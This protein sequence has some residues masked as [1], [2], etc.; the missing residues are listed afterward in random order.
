M[1]VAKKEG[2]DVFQVSNLRT[3]WI[4]VPPGKSKVVGRGGLEKEDT[5]F[6]FGF[7]FCFVFFVGI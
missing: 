6:K 7:G 1:E 2:A 4:A 3:G 5:V